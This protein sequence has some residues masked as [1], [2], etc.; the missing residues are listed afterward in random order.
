MSIQK[1]HHAAQSLEPKL[2]S[3]P[4]SVCA[5]SVSTMCPVGQPLYGSQS[6]SSKQLL[7]GASCLIMEKMPTLQP[8][9]LMKTDHKALHLLITD[10]SLSPL[11]KAQERWWIL[12]LCHVYISEERERRKEK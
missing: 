11:P 2:E 1:T 12:W 8:P 5:R 9:S 4:K 6:L 3:D 10:S 7:S